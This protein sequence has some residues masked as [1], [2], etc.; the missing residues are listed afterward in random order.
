MELSKK[1]LIM[2]DADEITKTALAAFF[3]ISRVTLDTR[4]SRGNWKVSELYLARQIS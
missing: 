4:L 3:G 1:L 2:I